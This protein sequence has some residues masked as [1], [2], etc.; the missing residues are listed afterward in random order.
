ML[1]K[2]DIKI[3]KKKEKGRKRESRKYEE[4][5]EDIRSLGYY[6]WLK[7]NWMSFLGTAHDAQRQLCVT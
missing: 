7:A 2:P 5:G 4:V 3:Q 1:Y 6:T